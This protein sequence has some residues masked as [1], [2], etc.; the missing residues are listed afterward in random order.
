LRRMLEWTEKEM[1]S[2]RNGIASKGICKNAEEMLMMIKI[3]ILS[4]LQVVNR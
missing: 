4:I 2:S 3:N 1:S